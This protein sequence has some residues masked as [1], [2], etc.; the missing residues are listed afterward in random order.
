M[1]KD[2]ESS[3]NNVDVTADEDYGDWPEKPEYGGVRRAALGTLLV[4][5]LGVG[6]FFAWQVLFPVDHRARAQEFLAD[7]DYR[8]AI[9]E[10]KNV[11]KDNP[12]DAELRWLLGDAYLQASQPTNAEDSLQEAYDLGERNPQLL[13]ALARS[14]YLVGEYEEALKLYREWSDVES[15]SD[16]AAWEVVRGGALLNLGK[17]EKAVDAYLQALRLD[18]GNTEAKSGLAQSGIGADLSGLSGE[19]VERALSTGLNEPETWILKGELELSQGD[20]KVSRAAFEKAVELGPEDVY[21]L[22]G[23]VRILIATDEL[24]DAEEPIAVLRKK[25]RTDPMSAYVRA[26]YANQLGDY[27]LA[28]D[29]LTIVL[30]QEPDHAMSIL[31][32]GEVQ[33]AMGNVELAL[34]SLNTFHRMVPGSV[35]GRKRLAEVLLESG[36]S[37][38]SVEL[39]EPL[40]DQ[41]SEDPEIA[42]LLATAYAQSGDKRRAKAY[43]SLSF[44]L[45]P[46]NAGTRVAV[47]NLNRGDTDEAIGELEQVVEQ[48]P[49][50]VESRIMLALARLNAGD[51]GKALEISTALLEEQ[52]EDPQ[53]QYLHGSALEMSNDAT[54]AVGFYERTLELDPKYSAAELALARIDLDSGRRDEAT[55]RIE[56]LLKKE[57]NNA[58][59]Q[60]WLAQMAMQD[61]KSSDAIRRFEAARASDKSALQPRLILADLYLQQRSVD[62]ALAVS[63]EIVKVAPDHPLGNYLLANALVMAGDYREGLQILLQ[64]EDTQKDN[65]KLKWRIVEAQEQMGDTAAV[66]D[67][68]QRVLSVDKQNARAL[69]KL[70]MVERNRDNTEAALKLAERLTEHHPDSGMGFLIKGQLLMDSGNFLPAADLLQ[71]AFAL[72]KDSVTV[73]RYFT[74][75]ARGGEG[76]KADKVMTDWLDANSQDSVARLAI[77]EQAMLEGDTAR[78]VQEYEAVLRGE[79]ENVAVLVL[80]GN[81]YHDAGDRRDLKTA[82]KA[83]ELAPDDIYAKHLYGWLLVDTGLSERG[84][85]LLREVLDQK[86]ENQ[87]FRYHLAAALNDSGADAQAKSVLQKLDSAKLLPAEQEEALALMQELGMETER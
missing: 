73:S 80:L 59:A 69:V 20:L 79:P 41:V 33:Y 50:K 84:A 68:L 12:R 83:F 2:S 5:G 48:N 19:E 28:L 14:N 13:L 11:I 35:L 25:F 76:D 27:E 22:S 72:N 36:A 4:L 16:A 7:E 71:R 31:L 53:V 15:D 65:L 87:S 62:N 45:D 21:A 30:K 9:I 51:Y 1:I 29:D 47:E 43:Q 70:A 82:Q 8:S 32:Q 74:A 86:P 6:G 64:L 49:G 46:E 39:L 75:L 17:Q 34:D 18:P 55:L 3:S 58:T 44:K 78:A 66:Y 23:L 63:R 56:A 85:K 54:S 37:A 42:S 67:T 52:P 38:R 77:A 40:V 26:L 57:P 61:G 10:L 81:A 60:V 24:E